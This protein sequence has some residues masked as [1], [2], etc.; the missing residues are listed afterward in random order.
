MG[1]TRRFRARCAWF[2]SASS[3]GFAL[4]LHAPASSKPAI[5]ANAN[6]SL[7]AGT[8]YDDNVFW[9]IED[10]PA[11]HY[12]GSETQAAPYPAVG[13]GFTQILPVLQGGLWLAERHRLT[14][15]FGLD[16]R[17]YFEQEWSTLAVGRLDYGVRVWR[18]LWI[19]VAAG[20][21]LFDRALYRT[22]RYYRGGADLGLSWAHPTRYSLQARMGAWM[23]RYPDPLREIDGVAQD[24][25]EHFVDLS[26]VWRAHSR[27]DI[28]GGYQFAWL[29]SSRANHSYLKHVARV[30]LRLKLPWRF[31]LNIAA[32]VGVLN[33]P[34]Y[35]L[36]VLVDTNEPSGATDIP[37]DPNTINTPE[38]PDTAST[39]DTPGSSGTPATPTPGAGATPDDLAGAP[40]DAVSSTLTDQT[41][42]RRDVFVRGSARLCWTATRY[43]DIWATYSVLGVWGNWS[44]DT[45]SSHRQQISVGISVRW[46]G[47]QRSRTPALAPDFRTEP[48]TDG[49][50]RVTFT[51]RAPK[52]RSVSVLG[53]FN[54]WDARR[55][56]MRRSSSGRWR[57]SIR[58]KP[59]RY[60][61]TF[62]V[63]NRTVSSPP[64]ARRLVSDGFGGHNGVLDVD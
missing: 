14:L 56:A 59:G 46:G 22:D 43:L 27:V 34:R 5:E 31:E 44:G 24:D 36:P 2:F 25:L 45:W 10:D 42:P 50:R 20:G 26:V 1:R 19:H 39:P 51:L 28:L 54:G 11:Y 64:G 15:D 41:A 23:R 63:D 7:G 29:V 35:T 9:R 16:F 40:Q 52:A 4:L 12:P 55:G 13:D 18:L 3:V 48:S 6:L 38:T 60:V 30:G 62:V 8:G 21:Q 37:V 57:L 49:R 32:Q 33:L 58:L 47:Q 17:W 53:S 61:Y